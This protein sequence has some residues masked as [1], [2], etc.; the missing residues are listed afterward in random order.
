MPRSPTRGS[1]PGTGARDCPG[2]VGTRSSRQRGVA[3]ETIGA[4]LD[5]LDPEFELRSAHALVRRKLNSTAGL[6]PGRAC[7]LRGCW[8]ARDIRPDWRWPSSGTR[9]TLKATGQP[10]SPTRWIEALIGQFLDRLRP[11]SNLDIIEG[12]T[13]DSGAPYVSST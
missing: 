5:S 7:A 12:S 13:R 8:R 4:A 10:A 2:S 1:S 6:D 9:W 3:D 11:G